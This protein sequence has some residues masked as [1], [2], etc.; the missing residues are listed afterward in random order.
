MKLAFPQ[1][2]RVHVFP[3]P[4]QQQ[5]QQQ[6][7]DE[8]ATERLSSVDHNK[9]QVLLAHHIRSGWEPH[10]ELE[11]ELSLKLA[12]A[13]AQTS[14]LETLRVQRSLIYSV[15]VEHSRNSLARFGL[16][17][18]SLTCDA[19]AAGEV[20]KL[21]LDEFSSLARRGGCSAGPRDGASAGAAASHVAAARQMTEW[22]KAARRNNSYHLFWVLDAWKRRAAADLAAADQLKQGQEDSFAAFRTAAAWV[23]AN[24]ASCTEEEAFCARVNAGLDRLDQTF[25]SLFADRVGLVMLPPLPESCI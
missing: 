15:T 11:T 17:F 5:Q 6:Q 24:A 1:V 9:A 7:T 3:A 13:V 20:T 18:T 21:A 16:V 25:A 19:G 12:C 2:E 8:A 14:L 10:A 22:H 4:R 23:D